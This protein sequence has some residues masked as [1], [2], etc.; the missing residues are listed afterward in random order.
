MAIELHDLTCQRGNAVLLNRLTH[1]IEAGQVTAVLG[2]NGA[3]KSTLLRM[4]ARE[5]N[6][7]AGSIAW[8][9]RP[10]GDWSAAEL[11]RIRGVLPQESSLNFPF[12]VREVVLL[13]RAPHLTGPETPRDEEIVRHAL[14]AAD[15][16][17]LAERLYP[18][19]SGGEKQRV[20]FARV[21]AQVLT[22]PKGRIP[23]I[24][25]DEPVSNLDP[26]HAFALLGEVRR[27]ANQGAGVVAILHDLNLAARF[28]DHLLLL[29]QGKLHA[30]GNPSSVLQPEIIRNVFAVDASLLQDPQ[31]RPFVALAPL[32]Y[33]RH[34]LD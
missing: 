21:L 4:L 15:L 1:R 27:L 9:G 30:H 29:K 11:A 18:T 6:P 12:T 25:L 31:N 17:N 20:Q 19:L 16:Q 8:E 3:G 5:W 14:A 10:L 34:P 28:A 13:G 7:S 26:A 24:L 33:P 23:W 32:D 2:P 22:P